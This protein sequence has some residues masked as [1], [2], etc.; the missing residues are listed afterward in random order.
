MATRIMALQEQSQSAKD[1]IIKYKM[2][3]C[4]LVSGVPAEELMGLVCE[5]NS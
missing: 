3:F 1:D 4:I 5:S 2:K